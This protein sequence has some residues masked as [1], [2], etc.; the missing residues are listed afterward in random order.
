MALCFKM[1][2]LLSKISKNVSAKKV[3]GRFING[4]MF[5]SLMESYIDALNSGGAPEIKSAWSRVMANQCNEARQ[6]ALDVY[7]HEL[8]VALSSR[9]KNTSISTNEDPCSF[10]PL[11]IESLVECHEIAKA[12]SK[13]L[14]RSKVMTPSN[15][16]YAIYIYN[17]D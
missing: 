14:F 4:D 9:H 5:C 10:F 2:N 17:R 7:N 3:L 11:E 13:E 8:V 12:K 6:Q 15:V 1:E 16:T